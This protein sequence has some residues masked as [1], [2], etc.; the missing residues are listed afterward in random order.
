MESIAPLTVYV[1]TNTTPFESVLDEFTQVFTNIG[2]RVEVFTG[3]KNIGG[4]LRIQLN[5]FNN[6][7]F[8]SPFYINPD[9]PG[10]V[11][12]MYDSRVLICQFF[13]SNLPFIEV[14]DN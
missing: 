14:H 10:I 7:V 11:Y 12:V 8:R 1:D 5:D 6:K 2:C 3:T 9:K 13:I 4:E